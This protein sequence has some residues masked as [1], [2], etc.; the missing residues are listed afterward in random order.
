MIDPSARALLG[1]LALASTLLMVGAVPAEA[2]GAGLG[3]EHIAA[4]RTAQNVALSPDGSLVAYILDVP[5]TPGQGKDGNPWRELHVVPTGGGA[6]HGYVSGEVNV[7][8]PRFSADGKHIF[9]LAKRDGDE[10]KSLW[11]I[12][13]NG[14]ESRRLLA[15]PTSIDAYDLS[16]DGKRIA[17]RAQEPEDAARK[18]AK[19]LGYDQEVYEEDKAH[20]G[21][22]IADLPAFAPTPADPTSEGAKP[23]EPRRLPIDGTA[24]H[25]RF[26][27]DGTR[28]LTAIQPL[29][30][31]DHRLMLR[32]V[33]ILDAE[34]GA[35]IAKFDNPGKLGDYEFSPDGDHIAMISAADPSDPREGRLM[36]A[37]AGGGEL[38]DLLPDLEGHVRKF[39]WS[40]DRTVHYIADVGSETILGRVDLDRGGEA[41]LRSGDDGIPVMVADMALAAGYAA[42]LGESPRH[43]KEVFVLAPEAGQPTRLTDSNPWLTDVQLARQEVIRWTASDG[44]ELEGILIHPLDGAEK[45]PL[46]LMVHGGPEA[47]D[48]NGWV[49]GYSRPGQ[50]AAA[51]G[52]AV[53]YPNYRGSTGRGVAFSKLGQRDAAG[54]EFQDLVEA[55]DHLVEIG[56][57][58][59]D[60]VG[61]TGGSY[62]GYATAWGATYYTDYFKAGVMFVG[63]SNKVSK[64][65]SSDIPI[66]DKMVHTTFDPWTNWQ[67]SLERSP[68]YHAENS[69]T[70]LL[71]AGGTGDTRVNPSQSLQMY[72]AFKMLGKTV[73]YVRYPDEPHGNRRAAAKDD[74]SRRILR[75]MNHFV[76]NGETGLPPVEIEDAGDP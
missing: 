72:R 34:T 13:V 26:S 1:P 71:V 32:R 67:F 16:A 55:V 69:K 10:H 22:W 58:D 2:S 62:G 29:N 12:P 52:Y 17:L 14:G 70:A 33:H 56:V 45:A 4:I 46:L 15:L 54:K 11:A 19:D 18:K 39:V 5:R 76:K 31:I 27:A 43:P 40:G 9:Y 64:G 44:L 47:N 23:S 35:V 51:H 20:M 21:L 30:L 65:F 36:T 24:S 73:R 25:P 37:P 8:S 7:G 42:F 53:L 66:E 49:T 38:M 68:I 75:W 6:S 48:R 28:I 50:I 60:R 59:R 61:I 74:Y 63:I 41:I 3:F 57:A